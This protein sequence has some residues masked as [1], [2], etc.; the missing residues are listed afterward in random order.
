MAPIWNPSVNHIKKPHTGCPPRA[1]PPPGSHAVLPLRWRGSTEI[2][3]SWR[4]DRS[5]TNGKEERKTKQGSPLAIEAQRK[6]TIRWRGPRW[7]DAPQTLACRSRALQACEKSPPSE[8]TA[9]R[10]RYR[11]VSYRIVLYSIACRIGNLPSVNGHRLLKCSHPLRW[12]HVDDAVYH[13]LVLVTLFPPT[14][15]K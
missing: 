6:S 15:A 9:I 13:L 8:E 5:Q 11:I 7:C 10:P 4:W 3:N 1:R 12:W 14:F 2:A